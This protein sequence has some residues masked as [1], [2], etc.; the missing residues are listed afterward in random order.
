MQTFSAQAQD[1]V[2]SSTTLRKF[3]IYTSACQSSV[4][5][6]IG[7][8][9]VIHTSLLLLIEH[10]L[11]NLATIFFGAET[12]ANNLDWEDQISEDGVVDGGQCSGAG[13]LLSL[14]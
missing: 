3:E 10:H 13:S 4:N 2:L 14:R 11:Q 1:L 6:R 8:E 7:I 9:S 5:L 12:L